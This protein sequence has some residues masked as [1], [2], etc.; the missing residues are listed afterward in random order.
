MQEFYVIK[1]AGWGTRGQTAPKT[2]I[3]H[4][5]AKFDK[6]APQTTLICL[7]LIRPSLVYPLLKTLRMK[8]RTSTNR[9]GT[10]PAITLVAITLVLIRFTIIR[11]LRNLRIPATPYELQNDILRM[12]PKMGTEQ[13]KS[14]F[15]G[16]ILFNFKPDG[17]RLIIRQL[18]HFDRGPAGRDSVD[19]TPLMTDAPFRQHAVFGSAFPAFGGQL[20]FSVSEIGRTSPGA[21]VQPVYRDR[22]IRSPIRSE[23]RSLGTQLGANA[24]FI[25]FDAGRQRI[26]EIVFDIT[27]LGK[28]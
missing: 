17:N 14:P 7:S 19:E 3:S 8:E 9:K 11:L 27:G 18:K 23:G 12:I 13:I 26:G 21:G 4:Q 16:R 15:V 28:P 10:P 2:S 25:E 1:V 6:I 24:Q 20:A 5:T 22:D